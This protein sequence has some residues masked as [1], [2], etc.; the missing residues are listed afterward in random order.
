MALG[1]VVF[2]TIFSLL[3]VIPI[4]LLYKIHFEEIHFEKRIETLPPYPND[5]NRNLLHFVQ[6]SDIHIS[7]FYDPS[8]INNFKEFSL[9]TIPLIKPEVILISG[10]LT[11]AKTQNKYG[12]YQY[13]DEW[14]TYSKVVD[15]IPYPIIDIRG[16]HDAFDEKSWETSSYKEF[17]K[18]RATRNKGMT[19]SKSF[20]NYTIV[21]VNAASE[22]GFRRPYNFIGYIPEKGRVEL[23]HIGESSQS[24]NHSIWFG[25]YPTP[26]MHRSYYY[27][28]FMGK[29]ATAYLCGHL[30]DA[31][32]RMQKIH[33]SGLA[34]LEL[35]DWK[36]NRIFRIL[37]FDHDILSTTDF[38]WSSNG[39]YIHLT[40]LPKW[41]LTN[42]DKQPVGR[43]SKST[44][45]RA[46]IFGGEESSLEPILKYNG[47]EIIFSRVSGTNLWTAPWSPSDRGIVEV[48][49]KSGGKT[50]KQVREYNADYDSVRPHK[51]SPLGN[52]LLT[53]DFCVYFSFFFWSGIVLS[54]A[55]MV[56]FSPF[57]QKV[58][59]RQSLVLRWQFLLRF[60]ILLGKEPYCTHLAYPLLAWLVAFAS[61][62]WAIGYVIGDQIGVIF[63]YGIYYDGEFH[64]RHEMYAEGFWSFITFV[65]PYLLYTSYFAERKWSEK[66]VSPFKSIFNFLFS[67][68]IP[69][70]FGLRVFSL[71]QIMWSYGFISG[72]SPIF[73]LPPFLVI[74]SS[75]YIFFKH[76]K[77]APNK[78]TTQ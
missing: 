3:A 35:S 29:Y 49:V 36:V 16:N 65:A 39:V 2:A 26:T 56:S 9:K 74:Y 31:V 46:L 58:V 25:H 24:S 48:S 7:K 71:Y 43:I 60:Q 77:T 51:Y 78:A 57:M 8:R 41:Q 69:I 30:H 54:V 1:R 20:G 12:S 32:P 4:G 13:E 75:F 33:S 53:V 11:D 59:G 68:L 76:P 18:K 72:I 67:I 47:K 23:E 21:A 17:T 50:W 66:S 44:H 10:D 70:I 64:I 14:K 73:G 52:F 45:L 55:I 28:D 22:P 6:I 37:S 38:K 27:R 34:E 62:P 40:N 5:E 42:P 61:L 63:A 15:N 19:I